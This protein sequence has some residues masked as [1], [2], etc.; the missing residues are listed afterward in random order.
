MITSKLA[1]A[2]LEGKQLRENKANETKKIKKISAEDAGVTA[3]EAK[4]EGEK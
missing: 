2:V 4:E 1:D 3:E